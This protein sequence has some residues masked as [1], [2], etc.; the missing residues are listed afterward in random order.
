L[1]ENINLN[2]ENKNLKDGY[3]KLNKEHNINFSIDCP[4]CL[5]DIEK[6]GLKYRGICGH[7]VCKECYDN[8]NTDFLNKKKCP[9]C[10]E[11]WNKNS[12]IVST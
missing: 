7:S 6:D 8:I 12:W 4:V 2:E 11:D 9:M 5:T 10:R 3:N 1:R